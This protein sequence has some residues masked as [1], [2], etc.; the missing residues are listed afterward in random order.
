MLKASAVNRDELVWNS[1]TSWLIDWFD[2]LLLILHAPCQ[3]TWRVLV[4]SLLLACSMLLIIVARCCM[5]SQPT[6]SVENVHRHMQSHCSQAG[7][8]PG[9]RLYI[10][11]VFTECPQNIGSGSISIFSANLIFDNRVMMQFTKQGNG[12]KRHEDRQTDTQTGHKTVNYEIQT[13][14][15]YWILLVG[16]C[17]WTA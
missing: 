5:A 15:V 14:K 9:R 8:F 3:P 1:S 13:H 17:E 12:Q 11:K 2:W 16:F 10:F 6:M 4:Y 7:S